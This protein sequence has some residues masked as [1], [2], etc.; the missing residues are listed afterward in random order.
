[1]TLVPTWLDGPA[2]RTRPRLVLIATSLGVLFAQIDTS[3]V[4]LAA[5]EHRRRSARRRQRD[6]VGRRLLQS[7][8]CEFAPDRWHAGRS[9]W[10][11]TNFRF[12]YRT[13]HRRYV[14]LRTGTKRRRLDWRTDCQRHR[15]GLRSPHVAGVAYAGLPGP[16]SERAHALGVWA[17]CNALAFIIGPM[18]GGWLVDTVGWRSIFYVILPVC[19][20]AVALTYVAVSESAEPER[21]A[22][23]LPGQALAIVGL[24]CI[25]FCRNR[26]FVLGLGLALDPVDR[27]HRPDGICCSSS[28]S[29][30]ARRDPCYLFSFCG[31]RY[32]QQRSPPRA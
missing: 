3:V 22:L 14:D 27:R 12:G 31:G 9:L 10:T 17:S 26:G 32:F 20:A 13:V 8:L 21:R 2:E 5:E 30:H 28:G 23:D 16:Q 24:V 15:R 29:K 7:R 1:M 11:Q 18:I 4:N 25:C 19:A 6:A